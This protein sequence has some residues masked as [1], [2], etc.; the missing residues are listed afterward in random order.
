MDFDALCFQ[1]V[2]K[3]RLLGR[4]GIVPRKDPGSGAF[5]SGFFYGPLALQIE[6]IQELLPVGGQVVHAE[7]NCTLLHVGIVAGRPLDF[8]QRRIGPEPFAIGA[9]RR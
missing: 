1:Q 8:R 6:I 9:C 5:V 4:A 7:E 3:I 2:Q